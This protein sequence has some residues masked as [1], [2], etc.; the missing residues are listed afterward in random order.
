MPLN[1][2]AAKPSSP[3]GMAN[4]AAQLA[5]VSLDSRPKDP[6]AADPAA[7]KPPTTLPPAPVPDVNPWS[8]QKP[9]TTAPLGSAES[10]TTKGSAQPLPETRAAPA[11]LKDLTA[12]P[13]PADTSLSPKTS[14]SPVTPTAQNPSAGKGKSDAKKT[15]GKWVPFEAEI[16]HKRHEGLSDTTSRR[17]GRRG[18]NKSARNGP[19]VDRTP[20]RAKAG[21]R[22]GITTTSG[23]DQPDDQA[24]RA[25]KSRDA[26]TGPTQV[27]NA[28]GRSKART[29]QSSRRPSNADGADQ[30]SKPDTN[31][32]SVSDSK[33]ARPARGAPRE[34]SNH[35]QPRNR[36]PNQRGRS[37]R[38]YRTNAHQRRPRVPPTNVPPPLPSTEGVDTTTLQEFVRNQ[39]EFY[40][41]V[42]NLV[43][44]VFFRSQMNEQGFVPLSLIAGFNRV[45]ALT[46][47]TT[48]LRAA[49]VESNEVELVGEGIRK[50]T[51]WQR[52]L[53]NTEA[54]SPTTLAPPTELT[55]PT[56]ATHSPEKSQPIATP[57]TVLPPP[58]QRLAPPHLAASHQ[59]P[60]LNPKFGPKGVAGPT[61][62]LGEYRIS[63]RRWSGM[64]Q[65]GQLGISRSRS[66]SRQR[67]PSNPRSSAGRKP[68]MQG[69]IFQFDDED[70]DDENDP[71]WV[72]R[73]ARKNTVRRPRSS[74]QPN[75]SDFSEGGD[76]FAMDSDFSDDYYDEDE[77]DIDDDTVAALLLVTERRRDRSHA[78][79]DRKAMNDDMA[80]LISEG[81]YHYE[82]DLRAGRHALPKPVSKVETITEEEF[83]KRHHQG[84]SEADTLADGKLTRPGRKSKRRPAPQ[85]IPVK[86]GSRRMSQSIPSHEAADSVFRP[87]SYTAR[88]H[89]AQ[90]HVG[91]LVGQHSSRVADSPSTSFTQPSSVGGA[92]HG[93][94]GSYDSQY[95]QSFG[96]SFDAMAHSFPAFEHP[97]HELLR[98]NGFVQH[99]YHRYHAR[100]VRERKRLGA[101]QSQEMN[102]LF[103]FWSHFLRENFNRRMYDEF[104]QLAIE[105]SHAK[106]RY[107][108]ECL[109]RFFSY[110]LEKKFRR[111]L[112]DDFQTLTLQ[113][114]QDGYLYGLEK[115]W[116]YQYYR[117]D[118]NTRE[119]AVKPELAAILTQFTTLEDFKKLKSKSSGGPATGSLAKTPVVTN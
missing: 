115:F 48:A 69:D 18:A 76:Q 54:P 90:V 86:G 74:V 91:W 109:F 36:V 107:G 5:S 32:G 25:T 9:V 27:S 97:S 114:H 71:D 24:S 93:M 59:R 44:D 43:K 41:S 40:F 6:K 66:G 82:R 73:S 53:L 16:T 106:Y 22:S 113:D 23:K 119:L 64:R 14:G 78:P 81:L 62:A 80:Q 21:P 61:L 37:F 12:W 10:S 29:A 30:A 33:G 26:S 58:G 102:T 8:A 96:T 1:A 57:S 77:D 94:A 99:K 104:K 111:D 110:G 31:G 68:S 56:T 45:K 116:A 13:A 11:P 89:D 39:V 55:S 60:P 79:F 20:G 28:P 65:R 38:S 118:K 17:S 95:G 49:L 85:F 47:D 75:D 19:A 92:R 34:N 103:R 35:S 100:A 15:K 83:R 87:A 70:D 112:Y 98:E 50:R 51:D 3:K 46:A 108:L 7:P 2:P 67:V 84:A 101:G 105:D 117:Q 63:S 88:E 42:E 52:W 72:P 4:V